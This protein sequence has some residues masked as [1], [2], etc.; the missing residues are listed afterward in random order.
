MASPSV[1]FSGDLTSTKKSVGTLGGQ[2]IEKKQYALFKNYPR[3]KTKFFPLG[4]IY[5]I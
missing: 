3:F 4:F 5:G 2:Y 1:F